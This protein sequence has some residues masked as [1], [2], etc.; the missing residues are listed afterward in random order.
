VRLGSALRQAATV[1]VSSVQWANLPFVDLAGA[2]DAV[3]A[4]EKLCPYELGL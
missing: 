1:D 4:R 3:T 2:I